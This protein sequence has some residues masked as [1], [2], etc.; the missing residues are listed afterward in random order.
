MNIE[1]LD[2]LDAIT[3]CL[4]DNEVVLLDF[5]AP[6]CGPCKR[7]EPILSEMASER[8]DVKIAKINVDSI[9]DIS[10]TFKIR[11]IPTFILMKNNEV[12]NR[13]SGAIDKNSLTT[14]LTESLV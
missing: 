2:S 6:W 7:M 13:K 9:M 12:L 4:E 3:M 10:E 11:S 14:F 1:N 5:W 8:A